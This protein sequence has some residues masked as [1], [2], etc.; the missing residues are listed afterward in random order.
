MKSHA[1]LAR[2]GTQRTNNDSASSASSASRLSRCLGRRRIPYGVA[3]GTSPS[4]DRKEKPD[5]NAH[6]SSL[7]STA[8]A[9]PALSKIM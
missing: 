8:P 9:A 7:C 2:K 6:D 4:N 3:A 5:Q 1:R